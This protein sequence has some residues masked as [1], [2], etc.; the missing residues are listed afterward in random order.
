MWDVCISKSENFLNKNETFFYVRPGYSNSSNQL[1]EEYF[2]PRPCI[3]NIIRECRPDLKGSYRNIDI[4]CRTLIGDIAEE[5]G[6]V[7][8][9]SNC[10]ICNGALDVGKSCEYN[11]G[12]GDTFRHVP[13]YEKA[14]IFCDPGLKLVNGRCVPPGRAYWPECKSVS[15]QLTI[16]DHEQDQAWDCS[17]EDA[18]VFRYL[19][20]SSESI[21]LFTVLHED[22]VIVEVDLMAI[23]N[24][25]RGI[26]SYIAAN[27]RDTRL[28]CAPT[29]IRLSHGCKVHVERSRESFVRDGEWVH[30]DLSEF[31]PVIIGG[32]NLLLFQQRLFLS[33]SIYHNSTIYALN[34]DKSGYTKTYSVSVFG[35]KRDISNCVM[36]ILTPPKFRIITAEANFLIESRGIFFHPSEYFIFDNDSV[37]V[38]LRTP[39]DVNLFMDRSGFL[40]ITTLGRVGFG[41]SSVSLALTLV[42]YSLFQEL[43]NLHGLVIINMVLA[44]LLSHI[45]L[46][47]VAE[48]VTHLPVV[49]TAIAASSH[50]FWLATFFWKTV[51]AFDLCK[52][53]S[54]DP[55]TALLANS[56]KVRKLLVYSAVGWGVPFVILAT[57]LGFHFHP[58]QEES[59][60]RYG[61]MDN[62]DMC[63]IVQPMANVVAFAVPCAICLCVNGVLFIS[64]MRNMLKVRRQPGNV[65]GTNKILHTNGWRVD[66]LIHAKV[67]HRQLISKRVV[68]KINNFLFEITEICKI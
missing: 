33:S 14:E 25:S 66:L 15:S 30:G 41:I 60:L 54:S 61:V 23:H 22:H 2:A 58:W 16:E 65:N 50:Y 19:E 51:L 49:C 36:A 59:L 42:T 24:M 3:S 52:T 45:L 4:A 40:T 7:F 12:F 55:A 46:A 21:G 44:L 1:P 47:F 11:L 56:G 62:A 8:A 39:E 68:L 63:W 10:A 34:E 29:R 32:E 48:F 26:D 43:R 9:N 67:I 17:G 31:E 18:N 57:C 38:C 64:T 35:V 6:K 13:W 20:E 28:L 5:K 37:L 27:P 53:L